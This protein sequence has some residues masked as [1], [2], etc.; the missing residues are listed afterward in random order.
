MYPSSQHLGPAPGSCEE[1][2]GLDWFL[3]LAQPSPAQPSPAQPSHCSV[4]SGARPRQHLQVRAALL[5]SETPTVSTGHNTVTSRLVVTRGRGQSG[6]NQGAQEAWRGTV[7]SYILPSSPDPNTKEAQIM[8]DAARHPPLLSSLRNQRD[9]D[10]DQ[11]FCSSRQTVERKPGLV[12]D[13]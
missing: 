5:H 6:G 2:G 8:S 11:K 9:F 3:V 10:G 13:N 4:A 1:V 7:T 12:C